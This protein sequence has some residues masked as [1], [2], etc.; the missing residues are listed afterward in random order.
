MLAADAPGEGFTS[1][2]LLGASIRSTIGV[3]LWKGDEILGVLQVDSRGAPALFQ[4]RDVDA[5]G[6]LAASASM[7]SRTRA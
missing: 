3:P 6:M 2:S 7:P 4:S 1:E 5:L